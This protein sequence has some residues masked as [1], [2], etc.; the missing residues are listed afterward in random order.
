M[1]HVILMILD[2][3][4]VFEV[5]GDN[6]LTQI[7]KNDQEFTK[8]NKNIK[9]DHENCYLTKRNQIKKCAKDILEALKFLHEKCELIHTDIKPENIAFCLSSSEKRLLIEN[10][11][12][13]KN[14]HNLAKNKSVKKP[15]KSK[16][17]LP[18]K[19]VEEEIKEMTDDLQKKFK[20]LN[21]SN[22]GK[23]DKL[24]ESESNKKNWKLVDFGTALKFDEKIEAV[25]TTRQYRAPEVIMGQNYDCSVDIWAVGCILFEMAT[26]DQL[27]KFKSSR[28]KDEDHLAMIKETFGKLP[29]R[30]GTNL[31]KCFNNKGHFRNIK[32]LDIWL[33]EDVLCEKYRFP[34]KE[35]NAFGAFLRKLLEPNPELRVTA[36]KAL[37]LPWLKQ[38]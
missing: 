16:Y 38:I 20:I 3:C 13:N 8:L 1:E 17:K 34:R 29:A 21:K 15:L 6:L 36:A 33:I 7:M 30:K 14:G 2:V 28:F 4:I 35:A 18:S 24:A 23:I 31:K 26:G 5:L 27:F 11:Q 19:T 9:F 10:C 37:E 25:I 32:K 22:F 12:N